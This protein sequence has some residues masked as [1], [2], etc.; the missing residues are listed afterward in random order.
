MTR[1]EE[2]V[3]AGASEF[4]RMIHGKRIIRAAGVFNG[5]SAI[6][7]ERAGFPALYLSGSGVAGAMGLPDLSITT[8][9]EVSRETRNITRIVR[10][11]LIVDADT[12]FGEPLN[13]IRTVRELES[14]G[15]AAIHIED[16]VI[17]KKC[18]HLSGKEL[19]Q[20]EEMLMKIRAAVK[21]RRNRDFT[22][23]ARTDAIAVEGLENAISRA[24]KYVE[25]GADAIF[26][27]APQT[28][29]E[30][31]IIGESLQ[32]PL[33]ANMTEFGKSP[34]MSASDLERMGFRIVIYP[35]TAFRAALKT[36]EEIYSRIMSEGSQKG[37]IDAL[38]TRDQFYNVIGYNQY[39]EMD[40]EL[41]GI[42]R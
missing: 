16:Q 34:I 41:S 40:R 23:I 35:L 15:A 33:L 18:G 38:M 22:I 32:V 8:L 29:E 13:V 26:V 25:A 24:K 14:S 2:N 19:V 37:F 6:L 7:A 30:F 9:T 21:A 1:L 5:I 27:E 36:M 28:P 12:G 42:R 20:T 11:P 4:S 39:E 31:R 3:N 17:P 10:P